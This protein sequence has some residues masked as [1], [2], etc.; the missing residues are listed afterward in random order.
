M[1]RRIHRYRGLV[2]ATVGLV[3]AGVAAGRPTLLLA[4]LVPLAFVVQG[5]VSSLSSLDGRVRVEREIRPETPLPGQPVEVTLRVTNVGESVMPDLRVLDGVPRELEV[6]GGDAR[7]GDALRSGETLTATYTL[8]ANRGSYA[9]RPVTLRAG[10][11]SGT[12]VT[13]T[14][15]EADGATEFDCRVTVEDMPLRRRTSTFTGS[16][17]TDTGGVGVEFHATRDYRRGDPVNR[18]NWRRYAKTGELSTVEYREQRAARVAVLIDGRDPAHVAAGTSLPTGATLSAHAATLAVGVLRDDG[19]HVG[20]GALGPEH[21]ITGGRPA[22]VP[23]DVEGFRLRPPPSA[24]R[25]RRDRTTRCPRTRCCRRRGRRAG[26]APRSPPRDGAGAPLYAGR[27][28]RDARGGGVDPRPRSRDDRPRA[29]RDGWIGRRASRRPRT[30]RSARPDATARG[31]GRR[32]ESR[33]TAAARPGPDA[34]GG[35]AVMASVDEGPT[36]GAG[37]S[38]PASL[39]AGL[40]VGGGL[41]LVAVAEGTVAGVGVTAAAGAGLG[42]AVLGNTRDGP[43]WT[44]AVSVLSPVVALAGVAGVVLLA[45]HRGAATLA[46][47]LALLPALALALGTGLAAF[48]ATGTLGDGI[49]EGAVSRTWRTA[50]A[51]AAVVG[52]AFGALAVTR[53]DALDSLPVPPVEFGAPLDPFL[54]PTAPTVGLRRSRR[55]SSPRPSPGARRCRRFPSWN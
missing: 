46:R 44:A 43:A 12:V 53:F 15:V 35:G 31:D 37:A 29:G 45:D 48:G 40:G 7:A 39:V 8:T 6:S 13:E 33:R 24:T 55:S 50:S 49:G 23:P 3:A 42:L 2:G 51:T 1:T 4:A 20:V 28:R 41:A 9:F 14:A 21:P 34:P 25:P 16:L 22:W 27:R 52:V 38:R 10:A 11:V 5:A 32:L 47:P 19:H 54:A 30:Q 17:S 36:L 26:P 18:I